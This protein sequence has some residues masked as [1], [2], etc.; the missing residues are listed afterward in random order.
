MTVGLAI[1]GGFAGLGLVFLFVI[2][3]TYRRQGRKARV[4]KLRNRVRRP[5]SVDVYEGVTVAS[6]SSQLHATMDVEDWRH[7]VRSD[8]E[9]DPRR[10]S[11]SSR[12]QRM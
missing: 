6:T 5:A 3:Y 7:N 1:G 8:S 12:Q 9:R 11:S 10:Y 2:S 4:E